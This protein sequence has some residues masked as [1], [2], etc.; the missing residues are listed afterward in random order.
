MHAAVDQAQVYYRGLTLLRALENFLP[1][2]QFTGHQDGILPVKYFISPFVALWCI[3]ALLRLLQQSPEVGAIIV[4]SFS[5][6]VFID[7]RGCQGDELGFEKIK[8]VPIRSS[9]KIVH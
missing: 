5:S 7:A 3:T 2:I 1:S 8:I 9:A 4:S 6:F